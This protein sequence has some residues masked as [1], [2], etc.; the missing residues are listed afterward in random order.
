MPDVRGHHQDKRTPWANRLRELTRGVAVGQIGGLGDLAQLAA[1]TSG[2][3]YLDGAS[4]GTGG[5]SNY[6][7]FSDDLVRILERNGI[8]TGQQPW[9]PGEWK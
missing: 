8:P 5:T 2:I 4:R 1:R 9:K 7:T 6:V 3:R